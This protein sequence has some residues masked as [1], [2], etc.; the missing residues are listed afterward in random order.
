[1]ANKDDK[2]PI[3]GENE[4]AG[5]LGKTGREGEELKLEEMVDRG[6]QK[7]R[8]WKEDGA[9]AHGL[10]KLQVAE[11]L[12]WGR[13]WCRNISAQYRCAVCKYTSELYFPCKGLLGLEIYC[14]SL[15]AC[16]EFII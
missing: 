14:N 5:F 3:R 11:F 6:G 15:L 1:L 16:F 7:E 13:K 8:N 2:W 12:S 9:E 4:E 10:E